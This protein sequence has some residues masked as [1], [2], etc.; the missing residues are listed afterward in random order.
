MTIADSLNQLKMQMHMERQNEFL[1]I[2]R[3][4]SIDHGEMNKLCRQVSIESPNLLN[5]DCVYNAI[6]PVA[7][8]PPTGARILIVY[9]G[10]CYRKN[11]ET[12]C[13]SIGSFS[14]ELSRE[15]S[16]I[17]ITAAT[18]K[19]MQASGSFGRLDQISSTTSNCGFRDAALFPGFEVAGVIETLGSELG[20]DCGYKVG[21]RVILYP[22]EGIP[23]GYSELMV[24][25]ELKYLVPVP[26]NLPLSI[27]A[28]LPTGALMA[29]STILAAQ[30]IIDNLTKKQDEK[31]PIKILIVGTGGLALWAV[32]IAAQHFYTKESQNRI[33]L[34]V[35]CLRDEGLELAKHEF[36]KVNIV[37]WSEDLYEKQ[38]IERTQNACKGL[39]DIVIDFGTT[40]RSL[41]RSLQCLNDGG[42]VL[43]SDEVAEKLL[44]K[45][46]RKA[47]ERKQHI[48]PVPTG[49]IEQLH[50]LVKLVATNEIQPPPHSVFPCEE[51]SE[52]VRKLVNSEIPGRAI[53]KFHDIE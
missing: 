48:E 27:A 21:Q 6:V 9:A 17:S 46:S 29:M 15:L 24:V 33:E 37:Q 50:E 5:K 23:A 38:L 52:V 18:L 2:G 35:A 11:R 44:P 42:V 16:D 28:M 13:T 36:D 30:K 19:Q 25:P 1:M 34:T 14:S 39:V 45:F 7:D 40:S 10:A 51:A 31:K 32:R 3:S 26:D 4:S 12:S 22:Y 8:C 53:L 20:E 41:H 43:V 47:E 49:T